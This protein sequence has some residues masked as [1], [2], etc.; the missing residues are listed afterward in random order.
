MVKSG[1]NRVSPNVQ[2]GS[3]RSTK[4]TK[5]K[6][7]KYSPAEEL[8]EEEESSFRSVEYD[9]ESGR[10][11]VDDSTSS[12]VV[13]RSSSP[14]FSETF[15][16]NKNTVTNSQKFSKNP[17]AQQKLNRRQLASFYPQF[18]IEKLKKIR[19][20][21]SQTFFAEGA[22]M[23]ADI[24]G[25][26]KL[27]GRLS[28]LGVDGLDELSKYTNSYI[29]DLVETVYRYGG[30]VVSFAGD[31]I[32]CVFLQGE[33]E[34]GETEGACCQR[35]VRCSIELKDYESLDL[36]AHIA[37]SYGEICFAMLG[38]HQKEWIYLIN[39]ECV[40]ELGDALTQA[41]AKES[42]C[43][44]ACHAQCVAFD[45]EFMQAEKLKD[46][47][48]KVFSTKEVLVDIAVKKEN[49]NTDKI[50]LHA[51]VPPCVNAAVLGG[52]FAFLSELREVTTM[53]LLL[54]SY[55]P[56]KNKD[57]LTLQPFFFGIQKI[58]KQTGG[59]MRQFLVDD[60]GCVL[61][62][63]WGV[64]KASHVNNCSRALQACVLVSNLCQTTDQ[65]CSIGLTTGD[66][67][68]GTVGSSIRQDYVAMGDPVNM[69][70]RLMC[71]AKGRIIVD[72]V[73]HSMLPQ[74]L[75]ASLNLAE[76]MML[77]GKTEPIRPYYYAED[78]LASMP[79]FESE[80][81]Y[82]VV[83]DPTI[84]I[85]MT[86][87]VDVLAEYQRSIESKEVVL[88]EG[89][90]PDVRI[91]H[92][93]GAPGSGKTECANR[94]VELSKQ[95]ELRAIRVRCYK[96]EQNTMYCIYRKII[97]ALMGP[98]NFT[99]EARQTEAVMTMLHYAFPNMELEDA[100]QKHFSLL[101]IALNLKW[102]FS[103]SKFSFPVL[104]KFR[105]FSLFGNK[106]LSQIMSALFQVCCTT[107]V[108]EDAHF[109]DDMSW[110]E[111]TQSLTGL[112][113]PLVVMLTFRQDAEANMNIRKTTTGNENTKTTDGTGDK[114]ELYNEKTS[115]M[116]S[117]AA[118]N[119]RKSSF[120]GGGG[121]K[122]MSVVQSIPKYGFGSQKGQERHLFFKS[123][124]NCKSLVIPLLQ[125]DDVHYIISSTL[126]EDVPKFLA[127]T[128]LDVSG[129][130]AYWVKSIARFITHT[131]I[132][133]FT[134]TMQD[135]S[136]ETSANPAANMR[137]RLE[138]HIVC[139]LE[140]FT[141]KVQSIAK[142]AA[143]IGDEFNAD[144]LKAILPHSVID[145]ESDL[146]TSLHTL[147]EEGIIFLIASDP[148]VYAFHNEIIRNTLYDFVLPSE[149]AVVHQYIAQTMERMFRADLTPYF[150]FLSY[151]F[152]MSP[153][154]MKPHAFYYIIRSADLELASAD[155]SMAY[156]YLQYALTFMEY[157][158]ELEVISK[159]T[160]G[161]MSDIMNYR[162]ASDSS[163][164]SEDEFKN[165]T[166][167]KTDLRAGVK[168]HKFGG[169]EMKRGGDI[170]IYDDDFLQ[171][172]KAGELS[173]G[174]V[175][176][177]GSGKEEAPVKKTKGGG[178][179]IS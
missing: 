111:I 31:A 144:L 67:Y 37:V 103:T 3:S 104:A 81:K 158:I 179:V 70:A 121:A 137:K 8:V 130:N 52:S 29:G 6:T 177:E 79:N 23:I 85:E 18:L 75:A 80:K 131:G 129:G 138:R 2:N 73:T 123:K 176:E 83:L 74:K 141:V 105:A 100:V 172:I 30:D 125:Y 136:A 173:I 120:F 63:I 27:C 5:K 34:F 164:F 102:S 145:D 152:A 78:F 10:Q 39:G 13:K 42:V 134:A 33:D 43:T 99:T 140:M 146:A 86:R 71:K 50:D 95:R 106:A 76:A 150:A 154:E 51:F 91:V 58:L 116:H 55:S 113:S 171:S 151:H 40:V 19:K 56:K 90:M 88:K 126:G 22:V 109:C 148:P 161:A 167:L 118:Q 9:H 35:A 45:E 26:V 12:K 84:T 122:V 117:S 49:I 17:A 94:F 160:D 139:H 54:D 97:V 135:R 1:R 92:I 87:E 114:K 38:G 115:R 72:T 112:K 174:A 59:F 66:A 68:C 44:S 170:S 149:A 65:A 133:H 169:V 60:K 28:A 57:L 11:C 155:F 62:A 53:F 127:E 36:T 47:S 4:K 108:I 178:C 165:Y 77:K 162:G 93:E 166:K 96:N 157:Q 16:I 98:V 101:K 124:Y 128:V 175:A 32:I 61:I 15:S 69:A 119:P 41:K 46:G 143:L 142:Y 21:T 107:I 147:S 168:S 159:V 163:P 89:T 14:S 82:S 48:W 156:T 25:F 24:S 153:A 7:K 20:I 64:P 132:D 110:K